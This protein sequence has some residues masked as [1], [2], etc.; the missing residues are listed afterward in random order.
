MASPPFSLTLSLPPEVA[1]ALSAAASQRGW[2][3]ESLAADC[4]AQSLEV[5][6]RHRV[7]LERIDKV[8]AALLELAKAVSAVEEASTP[9]ELS[10]FCRYRHGG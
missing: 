6:T 9:I 8:D 1:A 2:T 4:I 7:A 3:P 10:E 5:A